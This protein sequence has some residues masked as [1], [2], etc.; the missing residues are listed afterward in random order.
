MEKAI[1][2]DPELPGEHAGLAEL[3]LAS[4]QTDRA[5]VALQEA[6]RIDPYDATAY[7]LRGRALAAKSELAESLYNFEKATRLRPGYAPHLYDFGLALLS[8]DLPFLSTED[9]GGNSP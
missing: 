7:N 6:L 4:G 9:A 1:A 5:G 8:I 3:L 2:L